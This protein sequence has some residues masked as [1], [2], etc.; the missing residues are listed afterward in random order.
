VPALYSR[1]VYRTQL[2][3]RAAEVLRQFDSEQAWVLGAAAPSVSPATVLEDVE[4]LYL[5]DYARR[6]REFIADLRLV[7][8]TSL[9]QAAATA[10]WL[11]RP[12]SPLA[13]LLRA[14]VREIS[15]GAPS[16]E[17]ATGAAEPALDPAFETLRHYVSGQPAAVDGVTPLF[18]ALATQLVAVEDAVR[19]KRLPPAGD[20]PRAL[21]EAAR[22]APEPVQSML[23]QLASTSTTLAF[24]AAREPLARNLAGELAPACTRAV[25]G[26]YPLVRA[27]G[28]EISREVFVQTFG[29]NGLLDGFFQRHVAPHVDFSAQPWTFRGGPRD[30]GDS[31]VQFQR[32]REIRDRF[33]VDGGRRLGV[34]IELRLVALDPAIAD[35]T[36]DVDGQTMHFQRES[37]QAQVLNWPGAGGAG[38]IQLQ[39]VSA[40][41]AGAPYTFEGPWALLRLLERVRIEPGPRPDRFFLDFD[42]EGRTA[43]FDARSDTPLTPARRELLE[44]FQC[45]KRL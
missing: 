45:P 24:A 12:D 25:A 18:A 17:A 39:L 34:Q 9:A 4:R 33:F 26:R 14:L 35:F 28:D 6:W 16:G 40:A 3:E 11:A 8:P 21:A 13:A 36:I 7:T 38:R 5:A 43:R 42:I 31:L 30:G 19:H 15:V 29:A 41:G 32:A 44:H 27:G 20:A 37:R 1:V 23:A 22:R 2:R 10:Q